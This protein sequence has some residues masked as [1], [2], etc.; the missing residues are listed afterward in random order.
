MAINVLMCVECD[1][2]ERWSRGLCS[3]CY[4]TAHRGGFL[5]DYPTQKF[6]ND[7]EAYIR[8]AFGFYPELVGDIAVEFGKRVV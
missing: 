5:D 4:S 1:Q 3:S 8:W 2:R 7:P 6:L